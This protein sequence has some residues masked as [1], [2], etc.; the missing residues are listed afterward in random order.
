MLNSLTQLCWAWPNSAPACYQTFNA[1]KTAVVITGSKTD[2]Q[3]YKDTA[4]WTINGKKIKVVDSNDHLGLIVSGTDE[5][6]KNVDANIAKCRSALFGTLGP[7]FSYKCL[8]SPTTQLHVWRTCLLP[9]LMSGLPA[10]PI[11]KA[12]LKSL[13]LFHNKILRG[14]LKL[15]QSS[16]IPAS[17]FLLGE[18]PIEAVLQ[19]RTLGLFHN[20]WSN[21]NTTV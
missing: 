21:P 8:L 20:I 2:M 15:S 3:Y 17:H 16:P 1:D 11:R 5:E 9:V 18:L 12:Q 19:I 4:A 7:A 6:Q 14:I 10:L 13:T